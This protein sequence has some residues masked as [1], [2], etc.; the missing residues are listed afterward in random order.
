MPALSFNSLLELLHAVLIGGIIAVR[1][2]WPVWLLIAALWLVTRGLRY[3]AAFLGF[4]APP[5]RKPRR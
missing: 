2:L 4:S 5:A 3:V 1:Y